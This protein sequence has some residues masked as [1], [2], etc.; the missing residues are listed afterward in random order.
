MDYQPESLSKDDIIEKVTI[1]SRHNK[2]RKLC[3]N[4]ISKA[5]ELLS[6]SPFLTQ[7][8]IDS[9]VFDFPETDKSYHDDYIN[10]LIKELSINF[11]QA[12][13]ITSYS[14]SKDKTEQ[15]IQFLEKNNLILFINKKSPISF[16]AI[17]KSNIK[18]PEDAYGTSTKTSHV[19]IQFLIDFFTDDNNIEITEIS[20]KIDT[21]KRFQPVLDRLVYLLEKKEALSKKLKIIAL[22]DDKYKLKK[23]FLPL[24]NVAEL[25]QTILLSENPEDL[26]QS[27]YVDNITRLKEH[28]ESLQEKMNSLKLHID[29]SYQLEIKKQIGDECD[30]NLS[31]ARSFLAIEEKKQLNFSLKAIDTT[32]KKLA[33]VFNICTF[34]LYDQ[35]LI[36]FLDENN[37]IFNFLFKKNSE[38]LKLIVLYPKDYDMESLLKNHP[39]LN[40][41][42]GHF[43]KKPLKGRTL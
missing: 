33:P 11:S 2:E 12:N 13:S 4:N 20:Q 9:I 24:S 31:V 38:A 29:N 6:Q 36:N 7:E 8:M 5:K 32:C 28:F 10:S 1:I 19:S 27:S 21:R 18:I 37:F 22:F 35:D 42:K 34:S 25:Q 23:Q 17:I 43:S 26:I 14:D 30:Y 15:L 16:K 39:L 40:N 41:Y 3:T